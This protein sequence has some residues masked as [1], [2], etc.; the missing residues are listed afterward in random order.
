MVST[1]SEDW[2]K[3]PIIGLDLSE[4]SPNLP[5][6][7]ISILVNALKCE[8]VWPSNMRNCALCQNVLPNRAISFAASTRTQKPRCS[9]QKSMLRF[10]K[11][12][13][14]KR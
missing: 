4:Y 2:A 8:Q 10:K 9:A 5:G 3:F 13:L 12:D 1:L 7:T 6:A 11:R 14:S